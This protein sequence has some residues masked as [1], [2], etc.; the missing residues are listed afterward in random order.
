M[1]KLPSR[2]GPV[3]Y[4]LLLSGAMSFLVTGIAVI[5]NLGWVDGLLGVCVQS[6]LPAWRVAFTAVVMLAPLVRMVVGG[7]V[8][9][10]Q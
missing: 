10:E 3:L 6:W 5:H 2:F 9:P 8:E 1:K 4:A 7:C